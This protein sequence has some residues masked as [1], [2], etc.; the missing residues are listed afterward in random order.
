MNKKDF[1]GIMEQIDFLSQKYFGVVVDLGLGEYEL[2][3]NHISNFESKYDYY[4]K[5]YDDNMLHYH[6]PIRIVDVIAGDD[7]TTIVEGYELYNSDKE[8]RIM[9]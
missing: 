5:A 6:A 4:I 9:E 3:I 2:I 7:I 1:K 8:L